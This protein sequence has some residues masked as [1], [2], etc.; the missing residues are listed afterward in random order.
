M[1]IYDYVCQCGRKKEVVRKI[2]DIDRPV[3]CVCNR[4]MRRIIPGSQGKPVIMDYYSENLGER[5]TGPRH[6]RSVM[7]RLGVTERR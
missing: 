7:N 3:R 4:M 5:I 6:K 2:A 1:P